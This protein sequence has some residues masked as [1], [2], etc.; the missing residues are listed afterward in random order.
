VRRVEDWTI[1]TPVVSRFSWDYDARVP[2]VLALYEQAKKAQWNASTDVNWSAEVAFGSPRTENTQFALLGLESSPFARYDQRTWDSFR[3][4]FQTW[5]VSQFLHGE[6]GALI[7]TARLVEMLPDLDAK[8]YAASQVG[9]E[10]RHVEVFSRYL[11][12]KSPSAYPVS[13]A[14]GTLLK[15]ILRDERWD[16]TFLGMQI[17]VESLALASFR[18]AN[19]TFPDEL[20]RQITH[21][22]AR[23]EARHVAFG[24]LS[25]QHLY[26]E[27]TS[28]ELSERE[29]LVIEGAY[30]MRERFTLEDIWDRIGIKRDEGVAFAASN[31]VMVKYRQA[32][33]SKVVGTVA[34]IGLMTD[35]VRT[36]LTKLDLLDFAGGRDWKAIE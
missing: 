3:W 19:Y 14:L 2:R 31:E 17:M 29:E 34:R 16:M 33:F 5:M 36:Q 12:E 28:S 10:A 30:A 18:L 8:N 21:L 27:L 9:D 20:I 7:A 26:R 4:E 11:R 15:D 35:R 1:V 22:V 25:L 13:S 23:D 24:V 32:V 6:Q